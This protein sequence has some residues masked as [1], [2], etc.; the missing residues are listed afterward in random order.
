MT[1][2]KAVQGANIAQQD[3]FVE[4]VREYLGGAVEGLV[5]AVWGLTFKART[6]DM[7]ESPAISCVNKFMEMGIKVRAY[8]PEANASA[9]KAFD[10]KIE[11]GESAYEILEG[12]DGLVVCTDWQEF[13][14][15]DFET[16]VKKMRGHVIFDGRNLYDPDYVQKQGFDYVGI[17][18]DRWLMDSER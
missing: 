5:L 4:K 6:D 3:Y 12:A 9:A 2:A 10:G 14:A 15:P 7:R 16:M 17:G 13:R 11:I 8:D 18:R 1:I